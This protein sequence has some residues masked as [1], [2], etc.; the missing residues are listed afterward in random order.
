MSCTSRSKS[1][2]PTPTNFIWEFR[3]SE[4]SISMLMLRAFIQPYF[5]LP[6]SVWSILAT[7]LRIF[8]RSSFDPDTHRQKTNTAPHRFG[9]GSFGNGKTSVRASAGLF[10]DALS[11][12]VHIVCRQQSSLHR[13]QL[14]PRPSGNSER[15]LRWFA[16]VPASFRGEYR[17]R[18]GFFQLS[19]RRY[20][21]AEKLCASTDY[22]THL[23]YSG[24][25]C[26]SG[27]MVEADYV[28]K[29]TRHGELWVSKNLAEFIPGTHPITGQPN[30]TTANIQQRRLIDPG[31]L[32]A[33]GQ[34]QS[35][36]TAASILSSPR[37]VTGSPTLRSRTRIPGHTRSTSPVAI[38]RVWLVRTRIIWPAAVVLPI[39]TGVT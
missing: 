12:M 29:L 14:Q 31:Q 26:T 18:P 1:T 19:E 7:R 15:S 37:F 30:S 25:I 38:S 3:A 34:Y 2:E 16:S 17:H 13:H 35:E 23:R 11:G 27:R 9:V 20:L 39:L 10:T 22:L 4:P 28:G 21:L 32:G 6:H 8:Q 24:S 5:P 33:I 36:G